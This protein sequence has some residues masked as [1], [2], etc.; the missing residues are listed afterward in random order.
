MG[1]FKIEAKK[2]G[3]FLTGFLGVFN[4]NN[5]TTPITNKIKPNIE[6]NDKKALE[7][8]INILKTDIERA[9]YEFKQEVK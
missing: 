1:V 7:N 3:W 2:I 5:F 4:F 6:T 8:D 9:M